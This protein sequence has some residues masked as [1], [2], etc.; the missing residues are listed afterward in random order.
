MIIRLQISD[1]K[2]NLL[3]VRVDEHDK[4]WLPD[5]PGKVRSGPD[6]AN[7]PFQLTATSEGSFNDAFCYTIDSDSNW[8]RVMRFNGASSGRWGVFLKQGSGYLY[9]AGNLTMAAGIFTWTNLDASTSDS[10]DT[11]T[12][13]AVAASD[14]SSDGGDSADA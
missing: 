4:H 10:A 7:N 5:Y 11:D 6:W 9:D 8:I 13:S 14:D 2:N 1:S 3:T 12:D